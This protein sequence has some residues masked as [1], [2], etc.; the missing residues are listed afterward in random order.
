MD[1]E[2]LDARAKLAARMGKAQ[3]GGKGKFSIASHSH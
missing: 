1:Q 2:V 3:V